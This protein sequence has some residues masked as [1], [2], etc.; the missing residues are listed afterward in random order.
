MTPTTLEITSAAVGARCRPHTV[1]VSPRRAMNFAAALNDNNPVYF[2]DTRAGGI[3]AHPMLAVALTWPLS[4]G[5]DGTWEPGGIPPEARARQVHYNESITWHR[6]LLAVETLAIHGT[7]CAIRPHPAGTLAS[8]RYDA[9]D[10]A[11]NPV[12]T[13]FITG[14]MIGVVLT[15]NGAGGEGVPAIERC[16]EGLEGGWTQAIEISPLAAHVYDGCSDI[17]FPI[18]TSRAFALSVGLP[19]T[20]YHGTATLGLA[21]REIINREAGADPGRLAEVHCGF[22]GMVFPGTT[23]TLS[24]LG[25]RVESGLKTVYFD[26]IAAAGEPAIRNGR[27][28]FRP[29]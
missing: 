2:D 18:H 5:A 14:L 13:E 27:A 20:I 11:G 7:V 22:R 23:L 21:L 26:A 1:T 17:S 6:P 16:P 4:S 19:G 9:R 3:L 10:A 8:I 28:V 24:V 25:I 29:A 15:D 12:F